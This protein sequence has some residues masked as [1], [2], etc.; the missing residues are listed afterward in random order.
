MIYGILAIIVGLI[1]IFIGKSMPKLQQKLEAK[2]KERELQLQE[3][4]AAKEKV[5]N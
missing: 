4:K 1:A 2:A 5:N 3:K